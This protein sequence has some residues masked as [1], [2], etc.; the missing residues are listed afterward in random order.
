M[1]FATPY[2]TTFRSILVNK[3]PSC[4]NPERCILRLNGKR[5]APDLK[6]YGGRQR[7]CL[8]I[9]SVID[10]QKG[11]ANGSVNGYNTHINGFKDPA[12]VA[13]ERLFSQTQQLEEKIMAASNGLKD[14]KGKYD[15]NLEGLESDLQAALTALKKKEEEIQAAE[16]AVAKDWCRVESARKD[17]D[18]REKEI[19]AAQVLQESLEKELEKYREDY[20]VRAEELKKIKHRL[21]EKETETSSFQFA[22]V[23][24]EEELSRLSRELA[25]KN[26]ELSKTGAE[27]ESKDMLI[28]QASE[29]MAAQR[30]EIAELQRVLQERETELVKSEKEKREEE[31]KLKI[32]EANLEDRVVAWFLAQQELKKLAQ[33]VMKYKGSSLATEEE[34]ERTKNLLAQVKEE[35]KSSQKSIESYRQRLQAQDAQLELQRVEFSKQKNKIQSYETFLRHAH[36]EIENER[37]KLRLAEAHRQELEQHLANE[38]EKMDE[39]QKELHQ[40]KSYLNQSV[41]VV[42]SLK[43][44]LEKKDASF[45]DVQTLL[46]FKESEL[47]A[48]R[49]EMQRLKSDV[50]FVQRNLI[51]KDKDLVVAKKNLEGLHEEISQ[52]KGLMR[53]KED[54]LLKASLMLKD[55]EDQLKMMQFDLD[56]NKLKLS[57]AASVVE[58]IADLTKALV[59]SAKEGKALTMDEDSV[60]IQTNCELFATNRALLERELQLQHIQEKSVED[61]R[62]W[63]QSEA[64]LGSMK[65]CLRQKEKELL[66][67]HRTLALKDHEIKNFLTQWDVR[68][69]ELIEMREEVIEEA[70]GLNSLHAIVQKRMGGKT[71]GELALEKL[72]LDAAHLEIEAA[73]SALRNLADLSQKLLVET[74]TSLYIS[75]DN[76]VL[77]NNT[78]DME[79][80]IEAQKLGVKMS[81]RED[82][83]ALK[84]RLIERDAEIKRTQEAVTELSTLT[85]QLISEAGIKSFE[86]TNNLEE[87]TNNDI[88]TGKEMKADELETY[89]V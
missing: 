13:L 26:E 59:E 1:A 78:V 39:L 54:Q 37:E 11:N 7:N 41:E 72:E 6:K 19:I 60:L 21:N 49:L 24:K 69:K 35:L 34:L 75:T 74:K 71:L 66:E 70:N 65:E 84:E 89:A 58:H 36:L 30:S 87:A 28:S 47:V 82:L 83:A 46:Q 67:A 9:R 20:A 62:K 42:S 61:L 76:I 88:A 2:G 80:E 51:D 40:E 25:I 73:M 12:R 44:E 15:L 31:E 10:K 4:G 77:P 64:E 16:R 57:E 45:N 14:S 3:N 85:K 79:F 32:S 81:T 33:E 22:L 29:V 63:K 17:L 27:L 38:R 43:K 86:N 53:A 68:E 48:A 8:L 56:D 5:K 18:L 23:T 52:L 55:K 50:A